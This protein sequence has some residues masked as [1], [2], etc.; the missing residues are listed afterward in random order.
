MRGSSVLTR[1]LVLAITATSAL[2]ANRSKWAQL[3]ATSPDGII[4]LDSESYDEL[5]EEP[6]DYGVALVL[7]ALPA[8]FNCAP[9]R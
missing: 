4:K 3:A 5:L 2:A 9:C 1:A 7:T 8:N 6:R